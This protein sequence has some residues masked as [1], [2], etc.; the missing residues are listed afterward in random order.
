MGL[1]FLLSSL[2]VFSR[3]KFPVLFLKV[4]IKIVA[5]ASSW[6]IVG[7]QELPFDLYHHFGEGFSYKN[8]RVAKDV[9]QITHAY[10]DDTMVDSGIF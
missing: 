7:S 6:Q 4:E 10:M 5:V 3:C 1:T 8:T 2:F 9:D